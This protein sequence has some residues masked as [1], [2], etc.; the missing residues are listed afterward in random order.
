MKSI[1]LTKSADERILSINFLIKNDNFENYNYQ[2]VKEDYEYCISV[3]ND[4]F[5]TTQI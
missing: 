3:C 2:I 1:N 5:D 4:N